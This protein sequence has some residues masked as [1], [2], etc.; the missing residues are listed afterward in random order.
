[1]ILHSTPTC[2]NQEWSTSATRDAVILAAAKRLS[3]GEAG[4]NRAESCAQHSQQGSVTSARHSSRHIVLLQRSSPQAAEKAVPSYGEQKAKKHECCAQYAQQR[5]NGRREIQERCKQPSCGTW[6]SNGAS[7]RSGNRM[8]VRWGN[9]TG[10]F[11]EVNGGQRTQR[12]ALM[13][14][15][16]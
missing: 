10:G 15:L 1:G 3:Q 8:K 11:P 16:I 4:S 5:M 13:N 2:K 14:V 6:P 9:I 7:S 12:V